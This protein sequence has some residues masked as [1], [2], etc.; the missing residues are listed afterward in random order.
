MKNE[1]IAAIFRSIAQ[2]LE[3]NDEN[4]FR[5]RAY[6]RA[7]ETIRGIENLEERANNNTL[8]RI[9][10]IGQDLASKI[11]E[12]LSSGA[13]KH[14]EELKRDI[15]R[16]VLE[17]LDIPTIGPK[18]VKLFYQKFKI[19]N[20]AT[21]KKFAKSGKLL[22]LEGI[23]EKTVENILKGIDVMLRGKQR[24]DIAS[25][26][27]I[28]K[29]Y[30]AK[31]GKL[32]TVKKIE[33]A[34]SLRR[35]KEDVKD[36]DILIV[37]AKAKMV[38]DVFCGLPRV[39]TV[40]ARG[41]TKSS[42]RS[43]EGI[44]VDVRVVKLRSFGATLL[45]FTG[46]KNHNVNLRTLAARRNLKINEYGIFRG[47]K[48]LASKTET[49][50]Y[51]VLG[52]QYIA[53]E[54]REDS[55]EINLS[56]EK[57]L[58]HLIEEKNIKGDFHVHSLY[59][60][61]SSS[62]EEMARACKKRGYEYVMISDHSVRLR[63]A[64]GLSIRDVMKKKKE[65]DRLNKKIKNFKILFGTEAEI[66][67]QGNIDYD[68]KTLR[69]F[70][71][72][73]AAIHSGFKQSKDQL[74]MRLVRASSNQNVDIIAHPTGRLRGTRE[75]YDVD[76]DAVCEATKKNNTFLEINAFPDRLDLNTDLIRTAKA[77][78]VKFVIGTDAHHL[79]HLQFMRFGVALARRG[80]LE[81]KDVLN[82]MS[83]NKIL[84]VKTRIKNKLFT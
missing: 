17:L 68:S 22:E 72:V 65:I 8:T 48:C 6:Y 13:I 43:K 46:S 41:M 69:E 53:P 33:V 49:D 73:I 47:K 81:T 5:I 14:Y 51:R 23:K 52:M 60:D 40:I 20:I 80:G 71:F 75:P 67:A 45:Y 57:K 79:D 28:A 29:Y 26:W 3:I 11:K 66:D 77:K 30:V 18:T 34:G 9:P 83:L 42:I 74:T 12:Y 84:S 78:G 19:N 24:F 16:G 64:N 35:M 58:P 56:L 31:L 55:D 4:V 38:M 54:L 32:P 44:Q 39:N 21:L 37:S 59:S 76:F 15:P 82:T 50:I 2:I 7:A 36:I 70:D 27:E 62:I 1:E 10:G 25:A 61:G 63:I